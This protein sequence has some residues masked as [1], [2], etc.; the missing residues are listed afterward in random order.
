MENHQRL[1]KCIRIDDRR[2]VGRQLLHVPWY[3]GLH[4]IRKQGPIQIEK[5]GRGQ[6]VSPG[7]AS[8]VRNSAGRAWHSPQPIWASKPV[9]L[10]LGAIGGDLHLLLE[11]WE[12]SPK[13]RL[14]NQ[15]WAGIGKQKLWHRAGGAQGWFPGDWRRG[16][17]QQAAF[18]VI[19]S[20]EIISVKIL[21][22]FPSR[23]SHRIV[24]RCS[25]Y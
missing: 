4:G 5:Q 11:K 17:L 12:R 7:G 16:V 2:H 13:S 8:P 3:E 20:P 23:G 10:R 25:G 15:V 21:A 19:P 22:L 9:A 1:E 6:D 24:I 18:L 14:E